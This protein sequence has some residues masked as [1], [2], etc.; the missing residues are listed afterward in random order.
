MAQESEELKKQHEYRM[1]LMD[2]INELHSADNLNTILINIKDSIATLF[3]AE[4]LTIYVADAKRNLLI[5]KVKSGAELQQIVVPINDASLA[6]YCA[7]SGEALHIR[8]R[9]FQGR[10]KPEIRR[11]L[12]QEDRVCDQTGPLRAD[13][14]PENPD[15]RDADHQ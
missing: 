9:A 1:R 5:S 10:Q 8:K 14:V 4:R 2:K 15:R 12:G 13:E 6:G 3:S 11:Q 7:I